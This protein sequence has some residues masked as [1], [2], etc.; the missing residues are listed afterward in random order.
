MSSVNKVLLIGNLGQDPE[1]RYTDS[2]TPVGNFSIATTSK[3]K[4][5]DE[6]QEQTE[7]HKI[8]VWGKTAENCGQYLSKGRQVYIE[9]RLQTRKWEDKEGVKRYMTEIV[10]SNVVFLGS[11]GDGQKSE[12][13]E[14]P[15][16][17][18]APAG[19]GGY[20]GG[21]YD[22]SDCPF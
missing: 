16:P 10:A 19:D 17:A 5:G 11:K 14:E 4:K 6:W 13:R 8:V 22:E 21:G 20:P 12:R 2:G 9:G 7:W 3:F 15:A 1:V 18:S